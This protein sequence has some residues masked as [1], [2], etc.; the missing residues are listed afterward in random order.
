MFYVMLFFM[1]IWVIEDPHCFELEHMTPVSFFI[2]AFIIYCIVTLINSI[3]EDK[4]DKKNK[5]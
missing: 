5:K 2:L 3:R 1:F 4:N